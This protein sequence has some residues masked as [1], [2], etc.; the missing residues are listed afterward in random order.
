[1]RDP[2]VAVRHPDGAAV[3]RGVFRN[4]VADNR[5]RAA[6]DVDGAA[7]AA[8]LG[9][10]HAGVVAD[11]VVAENRGGAVVAADAATHAA[12][13]ADGGAGRIGVDVVVGDDVVLDRRRTLHDPDARTHAAAAVLDGEPGDASTVFVE[14]AVAVLLDGENAVRAAAVDDGRCGARDRLQV[15]AV[16]VEV[17][18]LLIGTVEGARFVAG[19]CARFVDGLLDAAHGVGDATVAHRARQGVD[20]AIVLAVAE[21]VAV[22]VAFAIGAPRAVIVLAVTELGRARVHGGIGVITVVATGLDA[23]VTVPVGVDRHHVA[24]GVPGVGVGSIGRIPEDRVFPGAAEAS[25]TR[26]E[27][28]EGEQTHRG[29]GGTP[30]FYSLG[31]ECQAGVWPDGGQRGSVGVGHRCAQRLASHHVLLRSAKAA[32]PLRE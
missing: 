15:H 32:R 25:V 8:G 10:V 21:R 18:I 11:D 9:T 26:G 23:V 6:A 14:V 17:D 2:S 28:H 3:A 12:S 24:V 30:G 20:R 19:G 27:K 5:G 29:P 4:V 13:R 1:M 7:V 16:A 22:G 31:R